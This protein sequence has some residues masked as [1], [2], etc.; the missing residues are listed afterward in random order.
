MSSNYNGFISNSSSTQTQTQ[1]CKAITLQLKNKLFKKDKKNSPYVSNKN[2]EG[3]HAVCLPGLG[4]SDYLTG[5]L[6][7]LLNSQEPHTAQT[8][9][10]PWSETHCP[11]KCGTHLFH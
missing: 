6:H 10:T 7:A 3:R 8:L 9:S 5:Q 4:G 2:L 1:F 11:P